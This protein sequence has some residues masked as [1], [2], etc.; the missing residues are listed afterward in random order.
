MQ[1]E[2]DLS[3]RF[4]RIFE[5]LYE[6][7]AATPDYY[8]VFDDVVPVLADLK[9]KGATLGVITNSDERTCSILE[10]LKLHSYFSFV[11]TSYGCGFEK[12]DAM[13]FQ[14]ALRRGGH[15]PEV[16]CHVGDDVIR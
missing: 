16:S 15:T 13:I 7:Y 6:G 10:A 5:E 8:A 11:L 4:P 9:S 1:L 12:P 14:E 3:P 2:T